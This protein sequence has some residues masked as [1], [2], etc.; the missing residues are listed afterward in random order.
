[1][2]YVVIVEAGIPWRNKKTML[3]RSIKHQDDKKM[4]ASGATEHSKDVM[5]SAIDPRTL[6]ELHNIHECKIRELLEINNLETKTE[7]NKSIKV[8][9]KDRG[10]IVKT[11]SRK[12]FFINI[13]MIRYANAMK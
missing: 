13:N 8:L 3:T 6:A 10:N 9:N 2:N 12:P 11:D 5:G 4:E 1:M 7:Y